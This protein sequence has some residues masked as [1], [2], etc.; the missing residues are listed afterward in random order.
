M[1]GQRGTRCHADVVA[2]D[3]ANHKRACRGAGAIDYP[4]AQSYAAR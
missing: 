3:H 1:E 2:G 4:V